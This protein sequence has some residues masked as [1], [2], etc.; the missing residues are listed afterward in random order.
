MDINQQIED[1][2]NQ[3]RAEG[4]DEEKLNRLMDLAVEEVMDIAMTE[5]ENNAS[6]EVL[7]QLA[8]EQDAEVKTPEEGINR[9]QKIFEAAYGES[10]EQKK[11]EMILAYLQDTLE[12]TKKA[13]DL[14]QKYQAGD[15]SAVA[16]VKAQEGNPDVDEVMKYMD[17]PTSEDVSL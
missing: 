9:L 15:P 3:L 8:S 6:D 2:K 12:Q 13:K 1:V 5:L 10:A 4:F 7:E 11:L 16:Q 17:K 14:L